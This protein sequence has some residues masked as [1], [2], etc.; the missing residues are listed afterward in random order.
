MMGVPKRAR[1]QSY[2]CSLH[3]VVGWC[4]PSRLIPLAGLNLHVDCQTLAICR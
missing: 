1:R 4:G 2:A 3:E